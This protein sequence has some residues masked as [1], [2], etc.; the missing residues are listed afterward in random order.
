[1]LGEH[2]LW[3][4]VGSITYNCQVNTG[5]CG[6]IWVLSHISNSNYHLTNYTSF[7]FN[8]TVYFDHLTLKSKIYKIT[9]GLEGEFISKRNTLRRNY[10]YFHNKYPKYIL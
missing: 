6:Y 10:F 7:E 3:I 2:S 9:S 4:Y 1:M 8:G 5:S